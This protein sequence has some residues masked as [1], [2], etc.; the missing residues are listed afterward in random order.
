M[1]NFRRAIGLRIKEN[2]EVY[3]GEVR[4][5]YTPFQVSTKLL[6]LNWCFT[7]ANILSSFLFLTN[8]LV[9]VTKFRCSAF[10]LLNFP[11]KKLTVQLVDMAKALAM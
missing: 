2:K 6:F 10:R 5:A 9:L 3:E 1:E 7:D 4:V 11:Q 8:I